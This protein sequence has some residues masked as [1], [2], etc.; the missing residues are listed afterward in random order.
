MV[1]E[2]QQ[3]AQS[4]GVLS[5]LGIDWKLFIAQLVNVSVVVFVMWRWVYR[6]LLKVLDERTKK[7]EK[8][9]KD[10]EEAAASRQAAGE[11]KQKIVLEARQKA[12]D[13][14]EEA[15][16]GAAAERDAA[17]R[18]AKEDVA[19]L[20]ALGKEQLA[21]EKARMIE[22]VRAEIGELVALAVEK[23]AAEKLDP[24]KD[25]ALIKKALAAGR[26]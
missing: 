9:L 6:P 20:V 23:I 13:I 4:T 15:A 21:D 3:V 1:A 12:K 25:E 14:G 5:S 10:A 11:E 16:A 19:R 26:K 8:G 17:I 18:K 7:I 2:A 24:K 22:E